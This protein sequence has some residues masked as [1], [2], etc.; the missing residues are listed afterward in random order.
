MDAVYR[1]LESV[2]GRAVLAC[3]ADVDGQPRD[4]VVK[5]RDMTHAQAAEFLH[6][7]ADAI[8]TVP[9]DHQ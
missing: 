5:P 9:E 6:A 4:F 7:V 1:C 8:T 3:I 2:G